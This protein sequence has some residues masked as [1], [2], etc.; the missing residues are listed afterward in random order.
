[1]MAGGALVFFPDCHAKIHQNAIHKVI[2]L[3]DRVK[4][5][6]FGHRLILAPCVLLLLHIH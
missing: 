1:M 5:L 4:I 3:H 2:D 6:H